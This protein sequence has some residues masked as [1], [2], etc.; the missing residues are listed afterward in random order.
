MAVDTT[1]LISIATITGGLGPSDRYPYKIGDNS[2]ICD[3]GTI[4][5]I[6]LKTGYTMWQFVNPYGLPNNCSEDRYQEYID[7]S[8]SEFDL[9]E[10]AFDGSEMKNDTE[11]V[12][13][14]VYVMV[15]DTDSVT[16]SIERGKFYGAITVVNEMVFVPSISGDIF[17]L[18]IFDGSLLHTI[19][20]PSNEDNT[21]RPGIGSGVTVT[22]THIV[23][24]CGRQIGRR[25]YNNDRFAPEGNIMISM[26]L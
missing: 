7:W 22:D 24:Y 18:D 1:N 4:H 13:N 23:F 21:N 20:C 11:T 10:R 6:D 2:I 3:T 19:Q 14:V 16:D 25:I 17:I 5:A 12:S 26:S 9:C 15:N 8:W